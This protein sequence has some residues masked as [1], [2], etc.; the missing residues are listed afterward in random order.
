MEKET[1]STKVLTEKGE[2]DSVCEEGL[3]TYSPTL[4]LICIRYNVWTKQKR[5]SF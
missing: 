1:G 2:R 4:F 3:N 5:H